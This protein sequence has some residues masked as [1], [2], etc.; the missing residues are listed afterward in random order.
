MAIRAVWHT[1][2]SAARGLIYWALDLWPYINGKAIVNGVNLAGLEA[3]DMLDVI[4]YFF[5]EDIRDLN[6]EQ[7]EYNNSVRDSI[8]KNLYEGKYKRVFAK[9]RSSNSY[10]FDE[11]LSAEEKPEPVK[12]FNPRSKKT[13]DYMAPSPVFNNPDKPFGNILE[14]PLN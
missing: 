8:Y 3:S 4:H 11:E 6:K 2:G 13:K 7:I 12:P 14:E 5:E 1:P 9:T 10:D